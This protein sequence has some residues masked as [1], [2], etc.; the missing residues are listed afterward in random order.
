MEKFT[1]DQF[2]GQPLDHHGLIAATI[3][4][5]G[6]VEK[7]DS[8]LPISRKNGAK[9]T[10]GQRVSAMILNG[11]GFI[12]SRLYMFPE[13]LENKPVARLLGQEVK[14]EYFND[15]ALG[16]CLDRIHD[17]GT[18]KL[19]SEIAFLI[20]AENKLL[21][22]SVH[23]DSSSLSVYGEYRD[24]DIPTVADNQS[25]E[26]QKTVIQPLASLP[27]TPVITHGYSK[28]HRPDLKQV[29]INLATTGASGF[30]IWFESHSGNAS[31]KK[32]LR[33]AA[34]RMQKFC[35]TL[36]AAPAFLY[37]ADSAMY[38]SCLKDGGQ[39]LWLSRV[40]EKHKAAKELLQRSDDDFCWRKCSNGYHICVIE[41]QYKGTHQRWCIVSSEQAYHRETKTL[42]ANIIKT[43][44]RAEK[45]LWHLTCKNYGCEQDAMTALSSFN[46]KLKYHFTEAKIISV[47]KHK[48]KGR[49]KNGAI[50][51]TVNYKIEGALIQDKE[52]IEKL[53]RQKGRFILATNQLD[54]AQLPDE[55]ML[56]EYKEQS[57][58]ESG[59]KFIKD[60]AFE[61]SSVF[62]KKP[63]RISALMMVMT[64][65]LM[66]YSV[67]QYHLRESLKAANDSIPDQ[68]KKPTQKPTLKRVLKLFHGVQVLT[69]RINDEVQELVINMNDVLKKI[70]AYFG[71]VAEAIYD[72]SG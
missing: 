63:S 8:R 70:V 6:L 50:S 34:E 55:E 57:K 30:P 66:V 29:V 47:K 61:V 23:F 40:P 4:K 39:L 22:S 67:A 24:Q 54:R 13:F 64:L 25:T 44:K 59:F 21:G 9:V 31:D 46:K 41:N 16:R 17:Y 28:D 52:R 19:F 14:A 68:R 11:L 48:G 37:V 33:E 27:K 3:E 10:M 62:L 56:P 53:R 35:K 65:C 7:I 36:S 72:A 15:D 58:T 5:L 26:E 32:I 18:T 69:I 45:D 60:D 38:E 49:P 12:D 51:E 71:P 42:N 20:G 43:E 1:E 2:S